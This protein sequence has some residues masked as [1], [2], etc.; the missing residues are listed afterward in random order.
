MYEFKYRDYSRITHIKLSKLSLNLNYIC[1]L[2]LSQIYF[3]VV[4]AMSINQFVQKKNLLQI[5]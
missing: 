1:L 3:L 2:K 5:Y 4:Q